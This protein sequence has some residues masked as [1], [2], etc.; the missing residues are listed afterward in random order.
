M[1]RHLNTIRP[2][3]WDVFFIKLL[4]AD[5]TQQGGHLVVFYWVP[6]VQTPHG[7]ALFVPVV[8]FFVNVI[9]FNFFLFEWHNKLLKKMQCIHFFFLWKLYAQWHQNKINKTCSFVN[10]YFVMHRQLSNFIRK[11]IFVFVFTYIITL[12]FFLNK[13]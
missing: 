7:T 11:K 1:L 3:Y 2:V 13:L 10:V 4:N 8:F 6:W 5:Y 12:S 9:V